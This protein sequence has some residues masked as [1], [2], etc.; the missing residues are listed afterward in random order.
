MNCSNQNE[1]ILQ[2][3][4]LSFIQENYLQLKPTHWEQEIDIIKFNLLSYKMRTVLLLLYFTVLLVDLYY[5]IR[6][7]FYDENEEICN[8]FIS[9]GYFAECQ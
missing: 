7:L 6:R 2:R 8:T 5:F 1:D 4:R 9:C 3:M